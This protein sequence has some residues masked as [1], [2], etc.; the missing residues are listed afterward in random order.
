MKTETIQVLTDVIVIDL[1][2]SNEPNANPNHE[3]VDLETDLQLH[4]EQEL[5]EEAENQRH[6]EEEMLFQAENLHQQQEEEEA[7]CLIQ[8]ELERQLQEELQIEADHRLQVQ[9][10]ELE[11]LEGER[12][13]RLRMVANKMRNLLTTNFLPPQQQIECVTIEHYSVQEAIT[14]GG[15]HCTPCHCCARNDPNECFWILKAIRMNMDGRMQVGDGKI[16][17]CGLIFTVP[18]STKSMLISWI[19]TLKTM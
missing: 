11:W 1:T 2:H 5:Q 15:D 13:V 10:Q 18:S 6:L 19:R 14:R 3:V 9:Q 16:I 8:A 4:I 12:R 7:Q 17:R